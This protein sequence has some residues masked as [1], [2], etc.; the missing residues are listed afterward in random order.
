MRAGVCRRARMCVSRAD[1]KKSEPTDN[2][3]VH[4]REGR[5]EQQ[6]HVAFVGV[7]WPTASEISENAA[8]F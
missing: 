4:N 8:A 1:R 2:K 5:R 3:P 6:L 7:T